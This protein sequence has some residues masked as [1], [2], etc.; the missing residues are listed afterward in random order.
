MLAVAEVRMRALAKIGYK[1]LNARVRSIIRLFRGAA[2]EKQSSASG[3]SAGSARATLL[4]RGDASRGS[5]TESARAT[6]L[7]RGDASRGSSTESARA[8]LL[9]R[10]D[11]PRGGIAPPRQR[12]AG[13]KVRDGFPFPPRLLHDFF[14]RAFGTEPVGGGISVPLLVIIVYSQNGMLIPPPRSCR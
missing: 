5:S 8:T 9:Q 14:G 3:T 13:L 7:R 4:Q 2:T 12:C 6:L 10:G 1:I 11:A